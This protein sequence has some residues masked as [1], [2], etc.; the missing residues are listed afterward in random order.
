MFFKVKN[1][2]F[3]MFFYLQSNVFNILWFDEHKKTNPQSKR[4]RRI[5]SG[6]RTPQSPDV[7]VTSGYR[8]QSD[9]RAI[10][11]AAWLPPQSPVS[12]DNRL[13]HKSLVDFLRCIR[14]TEVRDRLVS[15]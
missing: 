2:R 11:I 12:L 4:N 13:I 14:G 15:L 5:Q 6:D 9:P 1:T 8:V 7:S 3:V 10:I